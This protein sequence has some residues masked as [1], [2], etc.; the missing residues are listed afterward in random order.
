MRTKGTLSL[1][2]EFSERLYHFPK[3]DCHM[4]CW[5][6]DKKSLH[7]LLPD[8]FTNY[9]SGFEALAFSKLISLK[10]FKW[11]YPMTVEAK[12]CFLHLR[13]ICPINWGSMNDH[14][15]VLLSSPFPINFC[16][17]APTTH[18]SE[19][20]AAHSLWWTYFWWSCFFQLYYSRTR[21]C[22]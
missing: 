18:F 10:G 11:H 22:S 19:I 13:T 2:P 20:W 5:K 12:R 14:F 7:H 3:V 4:R 1:H 21:W 15:F 6:A 16:F 8:F 17:Q 9:F